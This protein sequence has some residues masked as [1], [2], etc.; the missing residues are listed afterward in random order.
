MFEGLLIIGKIKTDQTKPNMH[1]IIIIIMLLEQFT[2][3]KKALS[4][5]LCQKTLANELTTVDLNLILICQPGNLFKLIMLMNAEVSP[6]SLYTHNTD[7]NMC[8]NRRHIVNSLMTIH[9]G[10]FEAC[11]DCDNFQWREFDDVTH[12]TPEGEVTERIPGHCVVH[13]Q[14]QPTA[15]PTVL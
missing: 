8:S 6:L 2:K 9:L 5:G 15:P 1:V 4:V 7:F 11:A 3:I 10:I 13:V 14:Q 12:D